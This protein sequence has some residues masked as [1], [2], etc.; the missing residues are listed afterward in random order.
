MRKW[1]PI[2][3][4][5]AMLVLSVMFVP[6]VSEDSEAATGDIVLYSST[7]SIDLHSGSVV[8]F[9]VMVRNNLD[10]TYDVMMVTDKD[11]SDYSVS[12]DTD[13][14]ILEG[15]DIATVNVT[16]TSVKYADKMSDV[17]I[18]GAECYSFGT[19]TVTPNT[20]SIDVTTYSSYNNENSFNKFFG[21]LDNNLP[22]PFNAPLS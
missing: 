1:N 5:A 12:Y 20:L 18:I 22:S 21:I 13:S 19:G 14:F 15:G 3:L 9:Q 6:I 17:L 10:V 8:T 2:P 11:N 16:L 4:I 7:T